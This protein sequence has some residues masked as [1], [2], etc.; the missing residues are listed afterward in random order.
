MRGQHLRSWS[1]AI[2]LAAALWSA[3]ALRAHC[4]TLDGPVVAA[5]RVALDKGDNTPVLKWIRAGQEAEVRTAFEQALVERTK[6]PEARELAD[7]YFFETLVRVHGAGEGAPY[8]GL[9]PAGIKIP[10]GNRE[11]VTGVGR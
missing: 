11:P 4:D 6:G 5:A 7:R 9:K 3:P 8:T 10:L 1:A 2:C